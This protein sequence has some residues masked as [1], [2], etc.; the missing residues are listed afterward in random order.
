MDFT[1]STI[2][3]KLLWFVPFLFALCFHE[4]AHAFMAY[5][6]GDPTAKHLG[7]MTLNPIPHIDLILSLIHI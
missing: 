6:Q 5:K 2:A 1:I 7:R 3:E 4:A